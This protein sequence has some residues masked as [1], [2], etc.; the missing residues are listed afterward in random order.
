MATYTLDSFAVIAYFRNEQGAVQVEKMLIKAA[1]SNKPLSMCEVNF[2]ET[3]YMILRKHGKSAWES[4]ANILKSLPIQFY[5]ADRQQSDLA[6][7]FKAN[8]RISLADAFATALAKVTRSQ[9]V[10]GD[11]EFKCLE[12]EIKINWLK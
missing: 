5:P 12:K 9:L 2:A 3:K 8:H 7:Q 6:A 11:Q 1:N 4:T 10:T